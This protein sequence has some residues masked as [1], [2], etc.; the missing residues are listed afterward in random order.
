MQVCLKTPFFHIKVKQLYVYDYALFFF[1]VKVTHK[2]A[3]E[4]ENIEHCRDIV[5]LGFVVLL[6]CRNSSIISLPLGSD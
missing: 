2:F 5:V 6:L 1:Y 3:K 4:S